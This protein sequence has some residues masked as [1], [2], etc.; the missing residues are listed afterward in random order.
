MEIIPTLFYFHHDCLRHSAGPGHPESP[1]RLQ[2]VFTAL[3]PTR[4]PHLMRREAPLAGLEIPYGAHD[5]AYVDAILATVPDSGFR[6]IDS[7]TAISEGSGIAAL[8]AAGAVAAAVDNVLTNEAQRAFCAVRPPGHHAER[9][10]PMGFCVFNNVA[11]AAVH[12]RK[13]HGLE[14]VAVVDFDVHHGNG[15]QNIFAGDD[16]LFFAS[17]HQS[18]LYPGTG[19]QRKVA[20]NLVNVPLPS[21]ADGAAF[22]QAWETDILPALK[23]FAPQLILISAGFDG[24]ARDPLAGWNL[25]AEDFAWVTAAIAEVADTVPAA[26]RI[27][28]VLEGGYD[29]EALET[30]VAAHVTELSLRPV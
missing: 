2:A 18:V 17:S 15:T 9:G 29:L 5:P 21:G 30:S 12:A 28:S 25:L 7:D 13:A 14:R 10:R 6:Q 27:I 1:E 8:R 23:A 19:A 24:H 16:G 11:M 22:R 26:G 3:S 20:A 4:F